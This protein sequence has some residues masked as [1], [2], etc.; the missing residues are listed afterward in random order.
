MDRESQVIALL[1]SRYMEALLQQC[2]AII[3]VDASLTTSDGDI[4]YRS[5][6]VVFT[7]ANRPDS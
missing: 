5:S 3:N 6:L 4:V 1:H 7:Y 2:R